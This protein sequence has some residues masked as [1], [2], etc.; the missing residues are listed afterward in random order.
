MAE[1]HHPPILH[2]VDAVKPIWA[3]LATLAATSANA[4]VWMGVIKDWAAFVTVVV[5][6][7][8]AV[9]LFIYWTIKTVRLIHKKE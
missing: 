4:A 6:A 9:V 1:P 5:G 8:T 3:S 7:P 2:L